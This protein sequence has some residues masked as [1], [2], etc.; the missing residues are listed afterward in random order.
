VVHAHSTG[1]LFYMWLSD[2]YGEE[3]T[4]SFLKTYY[5]NYRYQN[6]DNEAL[7]RLIAAFFDEEA[8]AAYSRVVLGD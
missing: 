4:T 3:R 8:A 6:V 2:R 7:G 5:R 1:A